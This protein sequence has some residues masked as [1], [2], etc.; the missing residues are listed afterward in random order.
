MRKFLTKTFAHSKRG[1]YTYG[2]ILP[3]IGMIFFIIDYLINGV[4]TI[5]RITELTI[6]TGVAYF[7]L[8][9]SAFI[10]G[11]CSKRIEVVFLKHNVDNKSIRD[12]FNLVNN[13]T[14]VF[15]GSISMFVVFVITELLTYGKVIT[16]VDIVNFETN[17]L[18][19]I[20]MVILYIILLST[21]SIFP[22]LDYMFKFGYAR[23]CLKFCMS[24]ETDDMEKLEYLSKGINSYNFFL[25]KY[26]NMEMKNSDTI[27]SRLMCESTEDRKNLIER[28]EKSFVRGDLGPLE[29]IKKIITIKN[30]EDFFIKKQRFSNIRQLIPIIGSLFA[31]LYF[32]GQFFINIIYELIQNFQ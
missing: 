26:T 2:L 5:A 6:W 20:H 8:F 25:G 9:F 12:S 28:L 1:P 19:T 15:Y 4:T 22:R 14:K 23:I 3:S 30:P 18:F 16:S 24:D 13:T 21:L 10:V 32:G 17:F 7:F 29:Q 27:T 11:I 31:V